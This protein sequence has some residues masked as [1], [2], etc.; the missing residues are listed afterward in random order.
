MRLSWYCIMW[1]CQVAA[2]FEDLDIHERFQIRSRHR[3]YSM[4]LGSGD[5]SSPAIKRL[6][7]W[8]WRPEL[9]MLLNV[10]FGVDEGEATHA[11][12]EHVAVDVEAVLARAAEL[13]F[14][15]VEELILVLAEAY[16]I[17]DQVGCERDAVPQHE[18][19]IGEAIDLAFLAAQFLLGEHAT[20]LVVEDLTATGEVD[21]DGYRW[22]EVASEAELNDEH[23]LD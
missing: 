14:A 6:D 22:G 7:H 18:A 1:S 23:T 12:W 20:E 19:V 13:N 4:T 21:L 3:A 15:R 10:D 5:S 11:W 17:H 16:Y 8:A 2:R 9:R